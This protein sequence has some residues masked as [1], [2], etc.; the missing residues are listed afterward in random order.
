MALLRF[1]I[2]GCGSSGGVPRIGGIWGD[3]DPA[4]PKNQRTRCSLLI[5]RHDNGGVTRVLIDTSPDMRAQLIRERVPGLDAVFY[6]HSHADH[7]N[8]IDDLRQVVFLTHRRVPVWADGDTQNELISRF[9]YAFVQPDGSSYPPICDLH[10]IRGPVTVEGAGGRVTLDPFEVS[11]GDID[12]LG[13]RVEGVAYLPDVLSIPEPVWDSHLTGLDCWILDALR[14]KPHPTHAHLALSL[15]W[16]DRAKPRR[17]ILTN[18]HIDMD[19]ARVEAETPAHVS[20]AYDG[21]VLD[22]EV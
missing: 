22:Y 7:V 19:H 21:M 15:E 16:L 9:G 6:T 11:H 3:C 10:T 2:L 13:F 4:N 5:E 20:A 18:M 1:I 8:G 14:R 12:A 17:G